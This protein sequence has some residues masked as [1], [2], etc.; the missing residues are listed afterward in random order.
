MG[1]IGHMI[2][3]YV[4]ATLGSSAF[5]RNI[6]YVNWTSSASFRVKVVCYDF[7]SYAQHLTTRVEL[8]TAGWSR[9]SSKMHMQIDV[10]MVTTNLKFL[11]CNHS[12]F[13]DKFILSNHVDAPR[14]RR[15][16]QRPSRE[17]APRPWWNLLRVQWF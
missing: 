13:S 7:L 15:V 11:S 1:N 6:P 4:C 14:S 2:S 8:L 12:L 5:S 10:Q 9:V 3:K 16:M 17:P